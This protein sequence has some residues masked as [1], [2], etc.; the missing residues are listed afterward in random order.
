MQIFSRIP[1]WLQVLTIVAA[2]SLV[3]LPLF[4]NVSFAP[5]DY[6]YLQAVRDIQSGGGLAR[7]VEATVVENRW[8]DN[9]WIHEGTAVRFFRPLVILSYLTDGF[10]WGDDVRGY[11][12][13]NLFF[14]LL[15]TLI[16]WRLFLGIFTPSVAFLG[17]ILFGA[18]AVHTENLFY[19]AG[20]TDTIAGLFAVLTIHLHLSFR[21]GAKFPLLLAYFLALLGKEYNV[22]IPAIIFLHDRINRIQ[23][24]EIL[25]GYVSVTAI[26]LILRAFV[27][28]EDGSGG[29]PY[30]YFIFPGSPEFIN[31]LFSTLL[32]YVSGMAT[33]K[34]I[35]PFGQPLELR[36][37]AIG[38]FEIILALIWLGAVSSS[39]YHLKRKAAC[40]LAVG[41]SVVPLLFLYCSAR[42]LYLPSMGLIGLATFTLSKLADSAQLR[43]K[44]V[45]AFGFIFFG[46]LPILR[47]SEAMYRLPISYSKDPFNPAFLVRGLVET[48]ASSKI[49]ITGFT[50]DW[51]TLQFLPD[52]FAVLNDSPRPAITTLAVLDDESKLKTLS[53]N[54]VSDR[55]LIVSRTDDGPLY[56]PSRLR[57][58]PFPPPFLTRGTTLRK[59]G[60]LFTVL[61]ERNG[62]PTKLL[63][64]F[65]T[66]ISEYDLRAISGK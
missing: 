40:L 50:G 28:G 26:Y 25:I 63:V 13:T 46:I 14:H 11:A 1:S 2:S 44:I 21:G 12:L 23:R 66:S 19:I 36:I 4:Q 29:A 52:S 20:R 9:W 62:V 51:I 33:G 6:R 5:D 55:S 7:L 65:P 16:V 32:S 3:V 49:V 43:F 60:A 8:D 56:E 17:A 35:F 57:I 45:A 59:P 31:H 47:L 48:K 41:L 64:E 42:Y 24:R 39:V 27:L 61:E 58:P 37:N 15:V 30:P 22:L 38:A 34:N 10:L 53:I 54:P 18:H